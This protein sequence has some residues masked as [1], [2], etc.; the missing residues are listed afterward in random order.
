MSNEAHLFDQA[1]ETEAHVSIAPPDA[2]LAMPRQQLEAPA[3][4][5]AS[6]LARLMHFGGR[7]AQG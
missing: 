6:L 5:G 3:R 4:R 2:P 7:A 1:P